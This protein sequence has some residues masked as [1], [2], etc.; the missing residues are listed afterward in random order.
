MSKAAAERNLEARAEL[1]KG[2]GHPARLLILNLIE[3]KP[4][5]GEEL[6]AILGLG[7]ATVSHHLTKLMEV[8]VLESR[9]DQY[10]Q[11]YTLRRGA[12]APK[13]ADLVFVPQPG[14]SMR[15]EED[16]YRDR[17]LGAFLKR[18]RL[19]TIPAQRKKRQIVLERLVRE[20]APDR[21]YPEREVNQILVEFHDDVATLRR[22]LVG[23]R[24]MKR[25]GGIYRR[26]TTDE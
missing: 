25:A 12:L 10:Y 11:V 16:A 3:T 18:G 13:L 5:H 6:A 19:V 2:L 22:D 7:A 15:V 20:F 9:K 17:V 23:Y 1:F 14:I 26:V 21:D 8:G 24:L 4:R